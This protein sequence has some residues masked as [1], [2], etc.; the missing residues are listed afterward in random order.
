MRFEDEGI[1]GDESGCDLAHRNREG[2]IPG[3]DPGHHAYRTGD[4]PEL[5]IGFV[6]SEDFAI[7]AA[8]E[9]CVVTEP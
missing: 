8:I 1:S 6:R 7:D 4:D 5:F 2:E 9:L 3:D